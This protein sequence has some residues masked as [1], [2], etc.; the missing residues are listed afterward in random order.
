MSLPLSD[1]GFLLPE[2]TV[3]R[4]AEAWKSRE[5]MLLIIC[6]ILGILLLGLLISTA[7]ILLKVKGKYGRCRVLEA[8]GKAQGGKEAGLRCGLLGGMRVSEDSAEWSTIWQWLASWEHLPTGRIFPAC[9]AEVV[10]WRTR[11]R[12]CVCALEA[13]VGRQVSPLRTG[14]G[15]PGESKQ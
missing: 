11:L 2:S 7:F 14:P 5:L 9:P 10:H 3:T 13:E 6:I 12:V 1:L 4:Q 8:T 15:G